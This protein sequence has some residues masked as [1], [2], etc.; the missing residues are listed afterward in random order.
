M[1]H[2]RPRH[3]GRTPHAARTRLAAEWFDSLGNEQV[4]VE[5]QDVQTIVTDRVA[6]AHALVTFKGLSAE[7]E[8]PLARPHPEPLTAALLG[9]KGCPRGYNTLSESQQKWTAADSNRRST[10]AP[11]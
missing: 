11:T 2:E 7:G 4:A 10:P 3:I 5:F 8:H 6:V 9:R 1:N